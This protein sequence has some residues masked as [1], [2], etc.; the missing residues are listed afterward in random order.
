MDCCAAGSMGTPVRAPACCRGASPTRCVSRERA[1]A[2]TH[3]PRAPPGWPA[4]RSPPPLSA[5]QSSRMLRF[6]PRAHRTPRCGCPS[7]SCPP[8]SVGQAWTDPPS[9]AR[10]GTLA[11]H[12][13]RRQIFALTKITHT[14]QLATCEGLPGGQ[15]TAAQ[16]RGSV[17]WEVASILPSE[18]L[19]LL[20]GLPRVSRT[21]ASEPG[22]QR[23]D[24]QWP[25]TPPT[26]RRGSHHPAA[27]EAQVGGPGCPCLLPRAQASKLWRARGL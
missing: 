17:G 16:I 8:P 7:P 21:P 9:P 6:T 2:E 13:P 18:N 1:G 27:L 3:S 4:T 25:Q 24:P 14:Q 22:Q 20:S 5:G 10:G 15:P 26:R 11:I 23:A 19:T 12:S